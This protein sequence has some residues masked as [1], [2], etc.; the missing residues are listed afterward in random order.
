M[1]KNALML[2]IA[3]AILTCAVS[4]SAK[5][6]ADNDSTMKTVAAN[7]FLFCYKIDGPNL[8]AM[9]SYPTSGWVSVGFNPKKVMKDAS[10]IIGAV[11]QGTALV[12]EQFGTGMFSHKQ[13]TEVGGKNILLAGD[14]TIKDGVT[15]LSFTMPLD[16]G[17]SKHAKIVPGQAVKVIFAA[18]KTSDIG[19]KHSDTEKIT[20]TF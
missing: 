17:D 20:M 8:V 1:I 16:S 18:G 3:C 2:F 4:T 5:T 13:V 7:K 10:I 15:T 11:V 6:L 9:V 12:S 19:K 14:C